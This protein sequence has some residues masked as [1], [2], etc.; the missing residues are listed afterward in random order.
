M[1]SSICEKGRDAPKKPRL[2]SEGDEAHEA[3]GAELDQGVRHPGAARQEHRHRVRPAEDRRREI[4]PA[5]QH[6]GAEARRHEAEQ[7]VRQHAQG[8]ERVGVD[9]VHAAMIHP[10]GRGFC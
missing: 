10:P 4:A 9:D 3:R 2:A 7:I 5:P 1:R 8:E 6:E